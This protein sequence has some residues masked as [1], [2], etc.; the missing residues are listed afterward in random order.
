MPLFLRRGGA[1]GKREDDQGNIRLK[2][3]M[4]PRQNTKGRITKVVKSA[5]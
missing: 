2:M 1:G 5:E 3:T 4:S